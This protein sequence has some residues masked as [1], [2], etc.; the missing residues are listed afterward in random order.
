MYFEQLLWGYNATTNRIISGEG[1]G[2]VAKF[3]RVHTV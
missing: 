3:L 2:N 1:S